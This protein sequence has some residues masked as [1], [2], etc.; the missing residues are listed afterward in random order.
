M[1]TL[2]SNATPLFQIGIKTLESYLISK[3]IECRVV[4]LNL[5]GNNFD[6]KRNKKEILDIVCQSKL[7]GM[8]LMSNDLYIFTSLTN[9]IKN[10]TDIPV[11]WGGIHPSMC[12]DESIKICDF[13]CIGEGESPLHLLYNEISTGEE[14]FERVPNILYKKNG[15]AVRNPVKFYTENLDSLPFLD[16]EFRNSYIYYKN[17]FIKI[18]NNE[19]D[20]KKLLGT[21]MLFLSQ[22]GCSFSCTYCSNSF[23]WNLYSDNKKYIRFKSINRSIEELERFIKT[24]PFIKNIAIFDDNFLARKVDEIKEFACLYRKR[25]GL[26]FTILGIPN[27]VTEEKIRILTEAFLSYIIIGIQSGSD[28]ILK[29]LYHRPAFQKDILRAASAINKYKNKLR[30]SYDLILDN[31]YE[32]NS[33]KMETIKLL[34]LLPRPFDLQ[35]FSLNFFPGT[36]LYDKAKADGFLL[37]K[38]IHNIHKKRFNIDIETNYF[39]SIFLLSSIVLL[40]KRIN[41]LLINRIVLESVL[42]VPFRLI[43][44]KSTKLLLILKGLKYVLLSP[45]LLKHYMKYLFRK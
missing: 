14:N 7:I 12:P 29:S 5:Q 25:I 39:N 32:D 30:V 20:K 9:F 27:Y 37:E 18:P 23:L 16:Y 41:N 45:E 15:I 19:S 40:P 44:K 36:K 17:K 6:N 24:M 43:L 33:D 3:R 2:I 28:R 26:P 1:I 31:P 22:R 11:I 42:F 4:Y 13:V 35:L 38:D 10:E 21:N 34:N 8:S